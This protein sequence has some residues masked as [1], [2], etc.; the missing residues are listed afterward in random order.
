MRSKDAGLM[1]RIKNYAEEYAMQHNGA[2]PSSR[3]I[4]AARLA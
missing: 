3:D 1:E 2:T 4:A